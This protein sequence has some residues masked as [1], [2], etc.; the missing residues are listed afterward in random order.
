MTHS[1]SDNINFNFVTETSENLVNAIRRYLNQI[2]VVA[3]NEVE[4]FKNDSASYDETIAHRL[5]LIPLKVN[6]ISDKEIKL[7]L[8]VSKPGVVYSGELKGDIEVVYDKIPLAI[9]NKDQE[10][11][12]IAQTK[13]GEGNEHAKFIPGLIYYRNL[14]TLKTDAKAKEISEIFSRCYS[15][16]IDGKKIENNKTYELDICESCQDELSN[17][18]IILI[19]SNKII[20]FVES[21]GQ[22]EPNKIIPTIVKELKKDLNLVIKKL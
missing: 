4:I 3:I 17:L 5:G 8:S 2:Q 1:N 10:L 15:N 20:V 19:P 7:N 21:F 16:C 11:E 13:V 6:K 12:L 18:N 14:L 9:L 22:L